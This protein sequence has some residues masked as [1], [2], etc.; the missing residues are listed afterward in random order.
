MLTVVK[1]QI[2]SF[3]LIGRLSIF[4]L[5]VNNNNNYLGTLWELINPAIQISIYWFV[6]GWGIR[7]REPVGDDPYLYW[8]ISAIVVWFFIN[9]AITQGSKSIYSR[10][11]FIS[12]MSFPMSI[13]PTYVIMSKFYHNVLLTVIVAVILHFSGY[14]VTLYILQLPYFMVATIIILVAISLIT[15]TLA[16]IVRDVHN[17][18]V[19]TM[20]VLFYLTPLLWTPERMPEFVQTIMKLNPFYYIAEGYRAALLGKSWYFIE[21][22]TYTLYFW[23]LAVILLMIGSSLHVKFRSRFVD[24]M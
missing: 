9:P 1:E 11:N 14:P 20:R 17:M 16:T 3:Y 7:G 18:V 10:L 5:K 24:Y 12:K 13:I 23:V 8:M 6:F 22:G 21:N 15:S 19:S 4:E 2:S